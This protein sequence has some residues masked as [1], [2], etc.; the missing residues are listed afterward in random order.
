M[1]DRNNGDAWDSFSGDGG[2]SDSDSSGD[3]ST[4]ADE[5]LETNST[6]VPFPPGFDGPNKDGDGGVYKDDR[7][8]ATKLPESCR[9]P[10]VSLTW[11]LC[12]T[13]NNWSGNRLTIR[14]GD[15]AVVPFQMQCLTTLNPEN[16]DMQMKRIVCASL[17]S[18]LLLVCC[19]CKDC[20]I[21]DFKTL[22]EPIVVVCALTTNAP[23][24]TQN[25]FH[26]FSTGNFSRFSKDFAVDHITYV[27]GLCMFSDQFNLNYIG[28][29]V[30]LNLTRE[31]K[32][33]QVSRNLRAD[34]YETIEPLL[35][36]NSDPWK[37][38]LLPTFS[39]EDNHSLQHERAFPHSLI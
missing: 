20:G 13:W 22:G 4:S 38:N 33:G 37:R 24:E 39:L 19:G 1:K 6:P 7:D 9:T 34:D 3:S 21:E 25:P 17:F 27:P 12:P 28:G 23:V 26:S 31:G 15:R 30:V 14:F 32:W 29:R 5:S 18:G 16:G 10:A 8:P 11:S 35:L 36:S 2:S